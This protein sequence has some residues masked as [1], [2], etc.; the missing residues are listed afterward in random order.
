MEE[1]NSISAGDLLEAVRKQVEYYFSKE[2][3]QTDRYL[4]SLM[5]TNRAVPISAV[6]NVS[7]EYLILIL[8]IL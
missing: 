1:S 3:L 5:D 6:M 4:R 8:K 2:N 7:F